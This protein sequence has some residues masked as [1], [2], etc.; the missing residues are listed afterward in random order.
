ME[1]NKIILST[2]ASYDSPQEITKEQLDSIKSVLNSLAIAMA[3]L[4]DPQILIE[5]IGNALS[6]IVEALKEIYGDGIKGYEK[7]GEYGWTFSPSVE[8]DFFKNAPTSVEEANG[9]MEKYLNNDEIKSIKNALQIA[10][11]DTYEL[12][13]AFSCYSQGMYKSCCLM[14]FGIIDNKIYSYGLPNDKGK[15]KLGASFAKDYVKRKKYDEF[16][17]QGVFINILRTIETTFEYGDNFTNPM[18]VIKRSCLAHGMS[19]R[20]VSKLECFQVWCLAYSVWVL[21]DVIEESYESKNT[22]DELV[23]L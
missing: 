23:D 21:L 14:L 6:N 3:K 9:I 19:K 16:T 2:K 13:E 20:K 22:I 17:L 5:R 10:G 18:T 4:Y 12:E 8:Y 1:E 11:V 7:W 15:I